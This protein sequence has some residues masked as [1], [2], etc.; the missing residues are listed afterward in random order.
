MTSMNGTSESN[1]SQGYGTMEPCIS[2]ALGEPE[3]VIAYNTYQVKNYNNFEL[4]SFS[5]DAKRQ[6]REEHW[7][8]DLQK[9]YEAGRKM[10]EGKP[11]Q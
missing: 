8:Q 10:G 5:E 2:I 11:F 4:G 3:Q 7:E 1:N 6:Y 9:A